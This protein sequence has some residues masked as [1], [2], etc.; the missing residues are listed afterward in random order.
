MIELTDSFSKRIE[1]GKAK[2]LP[3]QEDIHPN[4]KLLDNRF[5]KQLRSNV[6][7]TGYLKTRPLSWREH[8]SDVKRLLNKMLESN[9][10][11]EYAT[12]RYSSYFSDADFW[13]VVFKQLIC[14]DEELDALLEDECLFWNDDIDIIESFVLKTI[15]KFDEKNGDAQ[16][17]LPM[18]R[19][20][21]DRRFAV[22]LLRESMFHA[23][24]YRELI[25]EY[26]QNWESERIAFMDLIIM[27]TAIA[28][29]VNFPTIPVNVTLNEY[30]DIAKAYSTAKSASFINGILD[31]IVNRL[32]TEKKILK[33]L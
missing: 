9:I 24:E 22:E 33:E 3:T 29:L 13:R 6:Q 17:L 32:R 25:S 1:T 26:A 12:D 23:A 30:I 4:V 19:D 31:S 28:E 20:E 11:A 21:D 27:Q 2:L 8:E 10:Y 16:P 14:Q 5:I 7:L 18:F 15:R